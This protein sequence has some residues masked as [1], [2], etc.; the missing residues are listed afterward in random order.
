MKTVKFQYKIVGE[1]TIEIDDGIMK[2]YGTTDPEEMA[3]V[4]ETEMKKD[5]STFLALT[6]D[7]SE[8]QVKVVVLEVKEEA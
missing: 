8:L 4:D 6:E 2:A 7:E 5:P 3:R 1:Y